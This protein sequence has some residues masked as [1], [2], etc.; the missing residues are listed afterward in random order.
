M[1]CSSSCFL[2]RLPYLLVITRVLKHSVAAHC[3]RWQYNALP[4]SSVFW[5]RATISDIS[6]HPSLYHYNIRSPYRLFFETV[7]LS[8][9]F[10]LL[11]AA[12][13]C[14]PVYFIHFFSYFNSILTIHSPDSTRSQFRSSLPQPSGMGSFRHQSFR[15]RDIDKDTAS[16]KSVYCL[17][18]F[19]V[20]KLIL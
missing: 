1:F 15:D 9:L 5:L 13:S 12:R 19:H 17:L 6:H 7:G 11:R 16:L 4:D 3:L 18:S 2:S 20:M 14:A 10:A 8:V